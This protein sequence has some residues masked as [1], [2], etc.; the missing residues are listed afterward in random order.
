M[1]QFL[2]KNWFAQSVVYHI[3][4]LGMLGCETFN[5][6]GPVRHRLP[7]LTRLIPHLCRIGVNAVYIGPVFESVRHGYDTRDYCRIDRRLGDNDDFARLVRELHDAG[8]RVIVDAVLNHTSREFWAFCEA[9]EQGKKARTWN[10]YKQMQFD[11]K[12]RLQCSTWH[13]YPELV[14]LNLENPDVRQ[15]LLDVVSLWVESFDIDG[16][17]LDTADCLDLGFIRAL[18]AHTDKLKKDFVL[19]GEISYGDCTKWAGPDMLHGATDYESYHCLY[20]SHNEGNYHKIAQLLERLYGGQGAY[21]SLWM[22][23][24]ADNHDNDRIASRLKKPQSLYPLYALLFTMPGTPS[25]YYGSEWGI[26][27]KRTQGYDADLPIRPAIS[28]AEL[29]NGHLRESIESASLCAWISKLAHI[30]VQSEALCSG[31]FRIIDVSDRLLVFERYT[32][33]E[34]IYCVISDD[35]AERR[36]SISIKNGEY[37]DYLTGDSFNVSDNVLDIGITPYGARVLIAHH[38]FGSL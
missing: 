22:Y 11:K 28:A 19:F 33:N 12:H 31:G 38:S 26:V 24:F 14:E 5:D 23:T 9:Q 17:R 36:V 13:G 18:R 20:Q 3:Y 4:P 15:Y 8:I 27:G 16:L 7:E 34:S 25:I 32:N 2:A 21:A 10:W 1:A 37:T 30:R 29:S 6:D 35:S